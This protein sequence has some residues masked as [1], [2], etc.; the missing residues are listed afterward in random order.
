[1]LYLLVEGIRLFGGYMKSTTKKLGLITGGVLIGLS[2]MALPINVYAFDPEKDQPAATKNLNK[3]VAD[4]LNP[5]DN[6]PVLRIY[7][8]QNVTAQLHDHL[9]AGVN[10]IFLSGAEKSGREAIVEAMLIDQTII[11][12]GADNFLDHKSALDKKFIVHSF[13]MG[14]ALDR[15]KD[16]LQSITKDQSSIENFMASDE[17]KRSATQNAQLSSLI[18]AIEDI[19]KMNEVAEAKARAS[20]STFGFIKEVHVLKLNIN[21]LTPG[22]SAQGAQGEFFEHI[23]RAMQMG[24]KMVIVISPEVYKKSFGQIEGMEHLSKMIEVVPLPEDHLRVLIYDEMNRVLKN[25][26]NA[27]IRKITVT[28]LVL[29]EM[30]RVLQLRGG[31]DA[32]VRVQDLMNQLINEKT[33]AVEREFAYL[34]SRMDHI[35]HELM[36][37]ADREV[38]RKLNLEK[39][40]ILLKFKALAVGT[41]TMED[42]LSPDFN[43]KNESKKISGVSAFAGKVLE[44]LKSFAGKPS[45]SADM[46]NEVLTW[47]DVL[48]V[49]EIE[50]NK[51]LR[52]ANMFSEKV[53][54]MKR[55]DISVEAV[56]RIAR[57]KWG[58]DENLL[59]IN[60]ENFK[61]NL[62]EFLDKRVI[63]MSQ[64][65]S[66]VTSDLAKEIQLASDNPKLERKSLFNVL[67]AGPTGTGKTEFVK[68]IADAMGAKIIRINGNELLDEHNSSR[69]IGSPAGYVGHG[70]PTIFD[71]IIKNPNKRFVFL[72]DEIDKI[73]PKVLLNLMSILDEGKITTAAGEKVSFKNVGIA[74][75]SNWAPE[76]FSLKVGSEAWFR[77]A[78]DLGVDINSTEFLSGS[79]KKRQQLILKQYLIKYKKTP[80]ELINR[81]SD[82]YV[83]PA[84]TP[85][86]ARRV[87]VKTLVNAQ[88][89]FRQRG[90]QVRFSADVV[91]YINK[92]YDKGGNGRGIESEY[93]AIDRLI[94]E[95]LF[96]AAEGSKNQRLDFYRKYV[97]VIDAP[98]ERN[99]FD[100]EVPAKETPTFD[101]ASADEIQEVKVKE[102]KVQYIAENRP[103]VSFVPLNEFEAARAEVIEEARKLQSQTPMTL[104]EWKN[105]PEEQRRKNN[106]GVYYQ[107]KE[108][109]GHQATEADRKRQVYESGNFLSKEM[110]KTLIERSRRK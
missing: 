81:V 60:P 5:K 23:K 78:V 90:V 104:E 100:I 18:Q 32:V 55:S 67:L 17:K 2:S 8:R 34:K 68:A 59:R 79:E 97:I 96:K 102:K 31:T 69:I 1:M 61:D 25:H 54:D 74:M 58:V 45:P 105:L 27:D 95:E 73:H 75:T 101:G 83:V 37:G 57:E 40:Q 28:T 53:H 33:V 49:D 4:R 86:I 62:I 9:L 108:A 109:L 12:D 41:L 107:Q 7:G 82:C 20:G 71:E 99:T 65:K 35:E 92:N 85:Y 21:G 84:F 89:S 98:M 6:S 94:N 88:E 93:R 38:V 77:Y 70:E 64:L 76:L 50:R 46:K 87:I 106:I 63:G 19:R 51:I 36:A 22:F 42:L 110:M 39:L 29:E 47:Q 103:R 3:S 66:E 48:P 80:P 14:E 91:A 26:P 16:S 11:L 13:E 10:T 44:S 15:Y 56:Y 72:I 24:V 30:V 43:I 52:D